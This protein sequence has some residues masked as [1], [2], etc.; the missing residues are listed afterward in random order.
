MVGRELEREILERKRAT[1]EAEFIA[2]YGRRRVGKTFLI[3]EF[4]Q[5][6][7]CFELTG[8]HGGSLADQLREF[9]KALG[10]AK[11]KRKIAQVPGS[12]QE[13]FWQLE[14][15]VGGLKKKKGSR[16]V[17]FLA[18]SYTHLTLPT[19]PYV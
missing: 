2:V 3:R 4:F 10:K 15:F 17:I 1:G 7:I 9:A 11:G 5:D 18:V 8:I 6:E 16:K 19:T 14:E 12:W 13:A